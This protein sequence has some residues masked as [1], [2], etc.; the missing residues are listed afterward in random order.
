MKLKLTSRFTGLLVAGVVFVAAS[1][2]LRV[3]LC[4]SA[5][6]SIDAGVGSLARVFALGAVYDLATCAMAFA[7]VVL[8]TLAIPDRLFRTKVSRYLIVGFYFIAVYVVLFDVAAEWFFWDEF[9]CRF[10]FVA[11]DYLVYTHELVGNIYESYHVGFI[12]PAMLV[13]A[14]GIVFLTRRWFLRMFDEPSAM[15][16]RLAP[17]AVWLAVAGLSLLLVSESWA[18]AG[19]NQINNELAKNG[20]SSLVNAFLNNS[21]DYQQFYISHD[22]K[23]VLQRL[24]KLIKTDNSTFVSD[25]PQDIT[26][27]ITNEG[28]ERQANVVV[29]VIESLSAEFMGVFGNNQHL[30][31][32]LDA[33]S[34][35]CMFFTNFYATGTRTDRGLE[36]ISLSI[37]PTPGRS[38]LKRPDNAGL[39]SI[40]HLFASRGYETKFIYGGFNRFDNMDG[41]F[42]GNGFATV[43]RSDFR[44]DEITFAN[45]WGVCDEDLFNRTLRE[46]DASAARGKKFF[47]VV[48][49]TSN[50]RPFTYP[51][52][53]DIPSGQGRSGGVKYADYALG[54]LLQKARQKPWFNDT[55]FVIVADHCASSAGKVEVPVDKYHIPLFIYAP[56]FISPR[57]VDKLAGQ[58]DLAPTLLG[59]L[60]FSYE[61][62]F[63]GRDI[64]QSG[65]GRVL[66]GN[67]Q[68]VGLVSDGKLS[69]LM[70]VKQTKTYAV[71]AKQEQHLVKTDQEL[72]DDTVSYYQGASYLLKHGLYG[73][74]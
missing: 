41:F 30:T 49:T 63:F 43:E 6:G 10:N 5:A 35:E 53:V 52:K 61:S 74:K 44:K 18:A 51:A 70:P 48:M 7:P 62:K 65:P 39:F 42:K 59:L 33:L 16:Q 15:R 29:L 17:A 27:Q 72:M 19:R 69:L 25:D 37:P 54:D 36:A 64:L 26:R 13:L 22:D 67:Y 50:H 4:I 3:A 24:R 56:A 8:L 1:L 73:A 28:P 2:V 14:A 21:I 31:P 58:I 38:L 47:S 60:H 71:A 66:L 46:C 11:V 40:G 57:Q 68:K 23:Q 12:L 9:T 32:N 20:L 34:K 45:A 55:V